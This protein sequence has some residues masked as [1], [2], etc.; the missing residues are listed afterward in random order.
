MQHTRNTHSPRPRLSLLLRAR[1]T[2]TTAR[3]PSGRTRATSSS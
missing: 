2:T 3:P 1:S